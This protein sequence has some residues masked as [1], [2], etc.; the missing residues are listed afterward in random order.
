M[1]GGVKLIQV[2]DVYLYEINMPLKAPFATAQGIYEQRRTV[3]IRLESTDGYIGYGECEAFADPWYTEETVCT[4]L[5]VLQ[6]SIIPFLKASTWLTPSHF[7]Q[8]IGWIKRHHFAKAGVEMALW[9]IYSQQM[10]RSI[11]SLIGGTRSRIDVGVVLGLNED[12]SKIIEQIEQYKPF[13]YKRFKI[14]IKPGLDENVIAA[15]RAYDEKLPLMVD[16][17]SAYTLND[18]ERLKRLD[19]YN[20][21]MIEQPLGESD[22][23]DHAELQR[24][25]KTPI[26]LDES[27]HSLE[28]AR[29]AITLES[30]QIINVKLGRVGGLTAARH[31]HDLCQNH[32]IPLWVGGMLESGVGRAHHVVLASLS[33][34]SIAGDISA[35]EKYWHR[36]IISPEIV[37]NNGQI[38]VP[39]G[40][41]LGY[42]VDLEQ[43]KRYTLATYKL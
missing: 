8:A 3:V 17:N 19:Q 33:Q 27:I 43:L 12:T 10:G 36:D 28:D 16:A 11:T 37:V 34:F 30:C 18:I 20:L 38:E 25:L 9:D 5:S 1:K 29:L 6:Q 22:F 32:H 23:L 14:K 24:H 7:A 2:E 26:C 35:S 39:T 13:G 21:M 4:V 42:T 15:I 31:I 41:G 40:A